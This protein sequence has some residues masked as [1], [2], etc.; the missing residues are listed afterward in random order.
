MV[1]I[2]E[3]LLDEN[4]TDPIVLVD[5]NGNKIE[6]AQIAVIPYNNRLY[7]ILKPLNKIEDVRDDEAIV[8]YVEETK[9]QNF[10][11]VEADKIVAMHVFTEYYNLLEED[12]KKNEWRN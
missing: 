10:L 1:D 12:L 7:C 11:K 3:I 5:D 9:E 6:F 4:N 2:Y 8:F